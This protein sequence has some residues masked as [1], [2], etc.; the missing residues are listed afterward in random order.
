MRAFVTGSSGGIGQYVVQALADKGIEVVGYDILD[1]RDIHD[2][3]QLKDSMEGCDIVIHLA[4]IPYQVIGKRWEDYWRTNVEG[5]QK[6]AQTAAELGVIHFVYASSSAY[7][8][9]HAGFPYKHEPLN[10]DTPNAVQRYTGRKLPE[11]TPFQEASLSYALS[12]VAAETVI[13]AYGLGGRMNVTALRFFPATRGEPYEGLFLKHETAGAAVAD[14][15]LSG[16]C[17]FDIRNVYDLR[18]DNV[19]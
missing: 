17:G 6:V 2:A 15:V 3:D 11:M 5:T 1:G 19:S 4:A 14:T 7:Y 8:G 13:A 10:E 9:A 16:G 18:S 12:K